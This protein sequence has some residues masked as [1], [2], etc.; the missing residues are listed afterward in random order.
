[1]RKV[2][3]CHFGKVIME[4]TGEAAHIVA[5]SAAVIG[6][7]LN[8]EGDIYDI[9]QAVFNRPRSYGNDAQPC[10]YVTR[11]DVKLLEHIV[12]WIAKHPGCRMRQ[13]QTKFSKSYSSV[14][15]LLFHAPEIFE[16][17]DYTLYHVSSFTW[18]MD[19]ERTCYLD[20]RGGGIKE[21][22]APGYYIPI[23]LKDAT[24]KQRKTL[25]VPAND[26][27]SKLGKIRVAARRRGYVDI[28]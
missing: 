8:D 24:K 28:G 7:S 23:T 19:L 25:M 10:R 15:N 21:K 4:H 12:E 22:P 16:E 20:V 2:T 1:M 3:E 11:Y 17:D 27:L 9:I 13:I 6:A 5:N 18:N 14:S 26:G